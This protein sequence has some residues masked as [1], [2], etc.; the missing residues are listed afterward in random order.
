MVLGLGTPF[1]D[2]ESPAGVEG[3]LRDDFHKIALGDVMGAGASN[4]DAAAGEELEG[5]EID[6]LVAAQGGLQVRF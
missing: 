6:F 4:E 2:A 3:G 5:L 1:Q